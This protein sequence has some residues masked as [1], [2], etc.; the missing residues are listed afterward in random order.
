[1]KY[2][3]L[4]L[5]SPAANLACDEALLDACDDGSGAEVLRFW[6]PEQCFVV[7]G[8]SNEVAREVNVAACRQAGLG[9]LRRCS[10][11]GAVLQGPGC[12]NYSLVL[13]ID[14][15]P[16]LESITGANRLIMERQRATLAGFLQ[17]NVE[18]RGC[19]D[20]AIGGLKFSG[21]AQRRKRHTLIFH[22][23]FLLRFDLSQM[24]RFLQMPSREPDY[25]EGRGHDRFLMNLDVPAPALKEALREAWAAR[26]S[27]SDVPDCRKLIEERYARD[28]WNLKF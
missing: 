9:I 12:L 15:H 14:G 24:D 17:Q 8:Y 22:G 4:T 27:L 3:D 25:R 1:M 19:T 20:L 18:I 21:N 16:A 28:D 13:R 23:T 7:A 11:G 26:T 10:G 2:L 6:Q 5:A